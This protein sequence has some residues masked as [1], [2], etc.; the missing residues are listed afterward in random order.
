MPEIRPNHLLVKNISVHGFYWGG[1]LRFNAPA[2][3]ESLATL[4]DWAGHGRIRPHVSEVL[5]LDRAAEGLER[6]RT[7]RST[8]KVVIAP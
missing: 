6:L 4:I 8:G 5:P 3:T 1:Y 2:L 7:R